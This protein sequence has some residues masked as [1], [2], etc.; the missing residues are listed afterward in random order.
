MKNNKNISEYL[1]TNV[2]LCGTMYMVRKT[3]A[4]KGEDIMI[5]AN[6][7]IHNVPERAYQSRYIVARYSEGSFWFWGAWNNGEEANEAAENIGG[8]VFENCQKQVS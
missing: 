6:A 5:I 1:L 3:L 8:V 7:T 4:F 2:L